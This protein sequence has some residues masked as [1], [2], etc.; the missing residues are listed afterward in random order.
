MK[1]ALKSKEITKEKQDSFI[2]KSE[3]VQDVVR[4]NFSVM[5]KL[6][7]SAWREKQLLE[8]KAEEN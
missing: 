3:F 5:K 1:N 8:K 4:T 2:E 7:L 6:A